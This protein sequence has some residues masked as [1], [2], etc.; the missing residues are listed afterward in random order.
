MGKDK[1]KACILGYLMEGTGSRVYGDTVD[2][3]NPPPLGMYITLG[4]PS[5]PELKINELVVHDCHRL[6]S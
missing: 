3:K 1:A 5:G 2:G 4:L 6:I